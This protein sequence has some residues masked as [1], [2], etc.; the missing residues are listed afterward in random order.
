MAGSVAME[1]VNTTV[2]YA[3]EAMAHDMLSYKRV[4]KIAKVVKIVFVWF[5]R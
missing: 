4:A 2:K 5:Q 3:A 1:E